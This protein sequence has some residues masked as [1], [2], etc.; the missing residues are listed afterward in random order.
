MTRGY[1]G[2]HVKEAEWSRNFSRRLFSAVDMPPEYLAKHDGSEHSAGRGSG[3]HAEPGSEDLTPT[4]YHFSKLEAARQRREDGRPSPKRTDAQTEMLARPVRQMTPYM[5]M[6][7]APLE[8]RLDVAIFRA[9][10]ASS[11]L[12]AKQFCTHGAVKVNGKVVSDPIFPQPR[13][14]R[15]HHLYTADT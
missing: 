15:S 9:M 14:T 5:Q 8:R 13:Y 7:F 10:F 1:H 12:Q 11:T 3:L 2:A 4:A 6:A